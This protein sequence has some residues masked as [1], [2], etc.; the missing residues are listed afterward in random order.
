M[1]MFSPING[2]DQQ[3]GVVFTAATINW[4]LGLT[5]NG[6]GNAMDIF[7]RNVLIRLG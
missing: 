6:S 1:G 3:R 2:P 7:T 4:V 5:L